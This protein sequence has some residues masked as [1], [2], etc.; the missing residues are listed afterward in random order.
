MFAGVKAVKKRVVMGNDLLK[1]ER[2]SIGSHVAVCGQDDVKTQAHG[3]PR[4]RIDAVLS[5]ASSDDEMPD[6]AC[7]KFRFEA[8]LEKRITGALVDDGLA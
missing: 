8:G 4:G 7:R 2:T 6:A 1:A 3:A 5:H